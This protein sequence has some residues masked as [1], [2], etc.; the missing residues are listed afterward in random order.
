M[1]PTSKGMA[2]STKLGKE[3]KELIKDEPKEEQKVEGGGSSDGAGRVCGN[4][5]RG[6]PVDIGDMSRQ[7]KSSEAVLVEGS[8][9]LY[10][11]LKGDTSRSAIQVEIAVCTKRSHVDSERAPC[12]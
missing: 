2:S 9:F 11:C 10:S 8:D 5:D 6:K 3:T 1:Q 12:L 7:W 4:L